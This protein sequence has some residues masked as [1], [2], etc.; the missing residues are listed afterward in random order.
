[1]PEDAVSSALRSAVHRQKP[2]EM[3]PQP[4]PDAGNR[5]NED[6]VVRRSVRASNTPKYLAE[7][8]LTKK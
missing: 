5:P 7:Y 2:V 8:V 3:A 6:V 1:M 4:M